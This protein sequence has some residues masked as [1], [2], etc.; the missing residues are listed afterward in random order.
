[1]KNNYFTSPQAQK[2]IGPALGC[3]AVFQRGAWLLL[4]ETIY[5]HAG[6][7][8]LTTN[9]AGRAQLTYTRDFLFFLHPYTRWA[10]KFSFPL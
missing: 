5:T 4:G 2:Y 8:K 6:K 9:F 3:R 10:L 1:M 7:A